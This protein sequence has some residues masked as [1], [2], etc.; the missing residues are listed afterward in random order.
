V[1]SDEICN[2]VDDD[3]DGEV[4][5]EAVDASTWYTDADGDGYGNDA[6]GVTACE[7]PAGAS[8]VGGDCVDVDVSIW[9]GAPEYCDGDDDD[10]D[11]TVDEDAVDAATWYTDADGD[12]FGDPSALILACDEPIS[13]SGDATDCDDTDAAVSPAGIEICNGVDDDCDDTIDLES[14]DESTWYAD[15]DGDGYGDPDD[16]TL[17]CDAPAGYG[18]DATDCDDADAAINPDATEVCNDLDDDCDGAV[19]AGATDASTWYAD[20][21]ADGYG[22]PSVATS[23]CVQ[24][25][26][27]V[28]DALDCDDADAAINPDATEVCNDLD[29]DCDGAVDEGATD[30]STWYADADADGY[31]DASTPTTAC[32]QPTGSIA[33]ATD[34]DDADAAINPDATEVCNDL[35]DD[36]DGAV[37]DAPTNETTWYA[38]T[39][40]DGYGDPSV[41]TTACD[42]PTG[43]VGNALDCDDADAT[44]QNCVDTDGDGLS[45]ADEIAGTLGWVTDET[46]ADTDGDGTND[47]D[48]AAP[49]DDFCAT[50]VYYSTDFDASPWSDWTLISGSWSWGSSE[51]RNTSL[52]TGANVWLGAE[53]WTDYSVQVTLQSNTSTG[54]A[55]FMFRT[56]SVSPINDRG[57]NYYVGIYPYYDEVALGYMDGSWHRLADTTVTIDT[58]VW[59]DLRIDVR[60]TDIDVYLDGTYLFSYSDSTYAYGSVGLRTFRNAT[61]YDSV[62]VCR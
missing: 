47:L 2:S 33:D 52:T 60:G 32:D 57:S 54:D 35:D 53:T 17:G 13:A 14:A 43:Y 59:Y 25:T 21:D 39:D 51:L 48:D 31:G 27:S 11:G 55:G 44:L 15:E 26:G 5:E 38:D 37:D 29:D 28:A 8:A 58:G 42:Q 45:D 4:D 30:A 18:A 12:G 6:R 61:D 9:P 22:D 41:S 56:Q 50:E 62:I 3:C 23:A 16:S 19:D 46:L 40:A 34:C 20:A 10:C 49:I 24:P 1:P 36:C 7:Q